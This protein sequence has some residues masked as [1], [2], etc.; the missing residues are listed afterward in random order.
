[1]VAKVRA[2]VCLLAVFLPLV[3]KGGGPEP[4]SVH[5]IVHSRVYQT[6]V[7]EPYVEIAVYSTQSPESPLFEGFTDGSGH[8]WLGLF[9][10]LPQ[11]L[12]VQVKRDRV[13]SAMEHTLP[14]VIAD[15]VGVVPRTDLACFATYNW[16][17]GAHDMHCYDWSLLAETAPTEKQ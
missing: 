9:A 1:M 11:Q 4:F 8:L 2:W 15:A 6:T 7:E 13:D 12:Y 17:T 3:V 14:L 5:V 16:D 10:D